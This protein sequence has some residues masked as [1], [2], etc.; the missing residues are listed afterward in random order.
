MESPLAETV[1]NRVSTYGQ[2]HRLLKTRLVAQTFRGPV[3]DLLYSLFIA[4]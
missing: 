4:I 1:G 3:N 2:P